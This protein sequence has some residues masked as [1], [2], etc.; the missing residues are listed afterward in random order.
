MGLAPLV[1]LT[2]LGAAFTVLGLPAY[3]QDYQPPMTEYG[4]PDLRG[5]WNFSSRTPLERPERFGE[6]EFLRDVDAATLNARPSRVV[7]T[8][9]NQVPSTTRVI[10]AYNGYWN[11]RMALQENS[12]TSLI[13]HPLNGRIPSVQDG[14]HV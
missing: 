14:V 5:V 13:V 11:D 2:I 10:G 1:R 6:I 8:G 3:A 4:Q 9:G 7:A 12:R